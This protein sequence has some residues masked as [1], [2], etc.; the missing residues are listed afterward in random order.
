VKS[1]SAA[2]MMIHGDRRL[3]IERRSY[4]YSGHYPERRIKND[5]RDGEDRRLCNSDEVD[6]D[7]RCTDC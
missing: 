6:L 5:R 7:R 3:G 2:T 4:Q 1:E